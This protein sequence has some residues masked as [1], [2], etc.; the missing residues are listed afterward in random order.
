MNEIIQLIQQKDY[1][2]AALVLSL[3]HIK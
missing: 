1:Q 3:S 2:V